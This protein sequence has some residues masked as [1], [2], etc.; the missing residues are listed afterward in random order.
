MKVKYLIERLQKFDL[1]AEVKLHGLKGNNLLFVNQFVGHEDIV[2]LED[3]GDNDLSS[4]LD[5]RYRCAGEVFDS[6][7]DFYMDLLDTGFTL[8]DIKENLPDVYES[9]KM[10][11]EEHGLV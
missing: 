7:L 2:I 4:E 11:C 10:F 1:E 9:T 8:E 6:E 5:E 3:K